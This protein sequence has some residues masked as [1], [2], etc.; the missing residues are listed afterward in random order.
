[1]GNSIFI[2]SGPGVLSLILSFK[3]KNCGKSQTDWSAKNERVHINLVPLFR[4]LKTPELN[5]AFEI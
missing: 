2:L 4:H 3:G 5:S 1:M